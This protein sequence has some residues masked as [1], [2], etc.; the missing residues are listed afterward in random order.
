MKIYMK[1]YMKTFYASIKNTREINKRKKTI[2]GYLM[3]QYIVKTNV[4]DG[5]VFVTY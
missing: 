1:I 4:I 5:L 2:L 3:L